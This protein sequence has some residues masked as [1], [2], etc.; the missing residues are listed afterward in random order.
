MV[1]RIIILGC[2][3]LFAGCVSDRPSAHFGNADKEKLLQAQIDLGIGYIR[4]GEYQRA[5]EN[6]TKAMDLDQRSPIV[7]NAFGLLFQLEG[8]DALA[9]EHFRKAVRFDPDF[10][11][12][13]NNFGAFLFEQERYE[14][15][16]EQL[17]AAA[18]DRFYRGRSSSF[19]NLGVSY[20]RLDRLEEAEAA[21]TRAIEL[22]PAQSRSLLELAYLRF[23]AQNYVSAR[24]LYIRYMTVASQNARS[25]W[26]GIRIARR[27]NDQDAEAS[28][29]LMLR[30]IFPASEEYKSLQESE[31]ESS[32]E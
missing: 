3:I 12:A 8:E 29:K 7:H 9:E 4:N 25:L 26:L 28:Y 27:F 14:E 13:R 10:S 6:L 22:N 17:Q 1:N 15:S 24:D 16:I 19:E 32:G 18:E 2:L 23:D 20:L 11:Q 21:F 30:N 31:R 5:K